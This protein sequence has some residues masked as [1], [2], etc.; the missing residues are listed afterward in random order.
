MLMASLPPTSLFP[1]CR[2]L[3][4][5]QMLYFQVI[6]VILTLET[7]ADSQLPF[8]RNFSCFSY[9]YSRGMFY[10]RHGISENR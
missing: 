8:L 9:L 3:P 5:I 6:Y 2:Q 7:W 10:S 4:I 1:Y